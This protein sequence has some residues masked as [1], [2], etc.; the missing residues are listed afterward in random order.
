MNFCE[1]ALHFELA[2]KHNTPLYSSSALR[3]APEY[4]NIEQ[5]EIDMIASIGP[6]LFSNY[7]IHQIEPIVAL[8]GSQVR[9]VMYIGSGQTD[10]F[11]ILFESGQ[12]ASVHH[13]VVIT[14]IY[15]LVIRTVLA[16]NLVQMRTFSLMPFKIWF[17][18]LNPVFHPLIPTKRSP[19]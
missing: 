3:Y 15:Q 10:A 16:W 4:A 11:L 9:K 8:L 13:L 18:S 17:V 19:L 1:I 6:G 14:S 2:S 7:G 12:T 5:S